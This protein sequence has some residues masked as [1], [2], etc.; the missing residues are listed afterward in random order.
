MARRA[1]PV[2]HDRYP[3]AAAEIQPPRSGRD[4]ER[5]SKTGGAPTQVAVAGHH[6]GRGAARRAHGGQAGHGLEG[7]KE[8]CLGHPGGAADHIGA[9]MH[10]VGEVH[11]EVAGRAEHH[12]VASCPSPVGVAGGVLGAGVR[13]HLHDPTSS[14]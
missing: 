5:S 2:V 7:P 8:H 11:I 13:L 4:T 1:D 12:S 14:L 6:A 3:T 10:P 9:P